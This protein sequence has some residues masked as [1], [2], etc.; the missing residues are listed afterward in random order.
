MTGAAPT[1]GAR[2]IAPSAYISRTMI[3]HYQ[4]APGRIT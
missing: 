1:R 2:V 4:I 3:E